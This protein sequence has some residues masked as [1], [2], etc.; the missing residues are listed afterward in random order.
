MEHEDRAPV[1]GDSAV[2][3]AVATLAALDGSP[4]REHVTVFESVH[5]A[6][7]DRLAEPAE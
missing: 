6:L 1:T 2:D 4:V 5:A 3:A 7:A